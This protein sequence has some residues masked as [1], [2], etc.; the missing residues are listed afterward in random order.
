[1]N[2]EDFEPYIRTMPHAEYPSGSSCVCEG[3]R[4]AM[5]VGGLRGPSEVWASLPDF[6]VGVQYLTPVA[7]RMWF[8]RRFSLAPTTSRPRS[9]A[10]WSSLH[11]RAAPRY[12]DT[13]ERRPPPS[14]SP[15][16]PRPRPDWRGKV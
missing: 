6:G 10:P 3:F 15:A 1:M 2:A 4:R 7:A 12:D 11:R 5:T 16:A 14:G 9:A 8:V 13:E